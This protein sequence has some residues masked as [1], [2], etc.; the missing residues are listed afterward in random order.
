MSCIVCTWNT[1]RVPKEV[2]DLVAIIVTIFY[3]N[4]DAFDY[5]LVYTVFFCDVSMIYNNSVFSCEVSMISLS[6]FPICLEDC[7]I[8]FCSRIQAT[9]PIHK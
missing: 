1:D 4:I 6:V 7:I 3:Y 9:I 2:Y 5:L 8:I